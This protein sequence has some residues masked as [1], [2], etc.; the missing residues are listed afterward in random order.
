M[1]TKKQ[2]QGMWVSVPTDW[3]EDGNFDEKTFRE[4]T[5]MLIEAG[6]HGLYT[7]GSTGEFYALDFA[8]FKLLTAAFMSEVNGKV[9]VQVG[10]NWF[11]TRDTIKRVQYARDKGADGVQICFPGWMEMPQYQYDQFMIDVYEAVPDIAIVH[12]NI[13]RTKKMFYGKDY[14]RLMPKIPTLIGTKAA[15]SLNDF[16]ELAV[17][18]PELNHFVGELSFPLAHQ[19]GAP[20][21]YTSWF[22][23]NPDFFH[24]YYSKCLND[25]PAAIKICRRLVK[26]RNEAVVP[27]IAKGYR[28]PVLDKPFIVM[29]GWLPSGIATRKPYTRISEEEFAGLKRKT[30]EIMPEFV[31]CYKP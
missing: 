25:L 15:M 9:P 6:A 18:A 5:G 20:G 10:A 7:T 17:Y 27:L 22:M 12:Y 28:D 21:M 4:T 1:L 3:D 11:N 19:F 16:M 24:D 30:E 2:L 23:M 13:M 8:E 31:G 26:W 14:V 29:G